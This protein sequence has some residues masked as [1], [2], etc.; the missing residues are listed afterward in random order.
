MERKS[1]RLFP[2]EEDLMM[3]NQNKKFKVHTN[4]M[5]N[6]MEDATEHNFTKRSQVL[7]SETNEKSASLVLKMRPINIAAYTG[8][9][10]VIGPD[11]VLSYLLEKGE[12]PSMIF[13]GPPGCGKVKFV[14]YSSLSCNF[15]FSVMNIFLYIFRH[16]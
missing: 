12:I 11:T 1:K 15:L 5:S 2:F 3:S 10:H 6:N 7:S 13:W 9:K 8:Q 16:P 14:L 4:K